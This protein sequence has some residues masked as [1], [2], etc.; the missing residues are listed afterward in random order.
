MHDVESGSRH[1][2]RRGTHLRRLGWLLGL[3]FAGSILALAVSG[4]GGSSQRS[5]LAGRTSRSARLVLAPACAPAARGVISRAVGAPVVQRAGESSQ[6]TPE[7]VIRSGAV[8]VTVEVDSF[9]QPYFRLER[10]A[11]EA[12]QQFSGLRVEAVPQV[13]SG[14]GIEAFWFPTERKLSVTEGRRLITVLVVWSGFRA[15]RREALAIA[16]ARR[17][18]GPP[19]PAAADPNGS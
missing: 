1:H 3:G 14:I 8:K 10:T 11:I 19:D 16:I 7:C 6:A 12:G 15:G 5:S 17:Y 18:L 9:P 4:C 13:V 2:L